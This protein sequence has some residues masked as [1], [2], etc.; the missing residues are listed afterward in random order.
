[1]TSRSILDFNTEGQASPFESLPNELILKILR[2]TSPLEKLK[3]STVC[4]KFDSLLKSD[5]AWS[6]KEFYIPMCG[7]SRKSFTVFFANTEFQNIK[8]HIHSI[9]KCLKDYEKEYEKAI[10]EDRVDNR[11]FILHEKIP[12]QIEYHTNSTK[13]LFEASKFAGR[14]ETILKLIKQLG[15]D[16]FTKSYYLTKYNQENLFD[17]LLREFLIFKKE[18]MSDEDFV[19]KIYNLIQMKVN[20]LKYANTDISSNLNFV[21]N[22]INEADFLKHSGERIQRDIRFHLIS[23][24]KYNSWLRPNPSNGG[25][26]RYY[27]KLDENN[28]I[29]YNSKLDI[30]NCY[31]Q[32]M[33]NNFLGVAVNLNEEQKKIFLKEIIHNIESSLVN[34]EECKAH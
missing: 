7:L 32:G 13:T 5:A 24:L 27:K 14:K 6:K 4:K 20:M 28:G 25:I 31:L 18:W 21:L 10:I 9:I 34:V 1:M 19:L 11:C 17:K 8:N 33:F 12:H 29:K 23:S 3:L 15:N 26:P 16:L 30:E 22:F 2:R